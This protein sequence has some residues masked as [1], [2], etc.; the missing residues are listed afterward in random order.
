MRAN[1]P[2]SR[3][4]PEQPTAVLRATRHHGELGDWTG[5]AFDQV[6]DYLHRH[7]VAPCGFPFARY[8]L[9]TDG[10]FEVEAGLPIPTPIAGDTHVQPSRLPAGHVVAVWHIGL[11]DQLG[12]AYEALDD[13]LRAHYG[14]R[15]GDPW[16][17]YHGP[18]RN[19]PQPWRT[20]VIQ[21]FALR[22]ATSMPI[23]RRTPVTTHEELG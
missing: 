15:T 11:Y 6:A 4:M 20:E 7:G 21:P 8:H 5:K 12:D 17:V 22:R 1:S 14:I 9:R 13:W 19:D 2:E 23:G 18:Q 16:E 3:T 10:S